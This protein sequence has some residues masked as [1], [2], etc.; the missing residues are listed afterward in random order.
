MPHTNR[1]IKFVPAGPNDIR[2]PYQSGINSA[3]NLVRRSSYCKQEFTVES[4]DI[5]P[6]DVIF[7]GNG[8][9]IGATSVRCHNCSKLFINRN[10]VTQ[11]YGYIDD[12]QY[13]PLEKVHVRE[14][15]MDDAI[16]YVK[17][18]FHKLVCK[19]KYNIPY[20]LF[21]EVASHRTHFLPQM[22]QLSILI[23]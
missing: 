17:I 6:D 10:R 8:R 18:T 21:L 4:R 3:R 12:K 23:P 13:L 20:S 22:L 2:V 5:V 15:S 1:T 19:G 14:A 11:G 16:E 7:S 9:R